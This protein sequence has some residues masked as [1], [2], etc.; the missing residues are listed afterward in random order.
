MESLLVNPFKQTTSAPKTPIHPERQGLSSVLT[1]EDGSQASKN[2]KV[3]VT[4]SAISVSIQDKPEEPIY[5]DAMNLWK[6]FPNAL[7]KDSPYAFA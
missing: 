2:R 1:V 5:D 6:D 7:A 4:K 3:Y